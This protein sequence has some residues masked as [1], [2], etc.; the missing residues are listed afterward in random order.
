MSKH[1]S[2]VNSKRGDVDVNVNIM[3]MRPLP[4]PHLSS[5]PPPA[6]ASFGRAAQRVSDNSVPRGADPLIRSSSLSSREIPPTVIGPFRL[7]FFF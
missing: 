4:R 7:P 5:L 1:T 2:T 6:L 3:D